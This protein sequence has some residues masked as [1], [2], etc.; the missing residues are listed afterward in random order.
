MTL[1]TAA[2]WANIITGAFAVVA[3]LGGFFWWLGA[4]K[5][6][7]KQLRSHM[8]V[9]KKLHENYTDFDQEI[10]R[11]LQDSTVDIPR[12]TLVTLTGINSNLGS[13]YRL[14]GVHSAF[15]VAGSYE[16]L[17]WKL[18]SPIAKKEGGD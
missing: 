5:N 12:R 2:L 1:E 7:E 16:E 9:L 14:I 8:K 13:L 6:R 15:S 3:G 10:M 4:R 17:E 11:I 18:R